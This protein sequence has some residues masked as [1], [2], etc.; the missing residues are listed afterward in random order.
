M[1]AIKQVAKARGISKRELYRKVTP[2]P[3]AVPAPHS[4]PRRIARRLLLD[5]LRD[6]PNHRRMRSHRAGA[7]HVNTQFLADCA[8]S[9]S[10]S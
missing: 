6:H 8:A 2:E 7:D 5:Q 9:V 3:D 4:S 10:R 1:D